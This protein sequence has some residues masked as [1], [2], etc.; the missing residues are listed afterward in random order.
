MGLPAVLAGLMVAFG[1]ATDHFLSA[2]TLRTIANQVPDAMLVATGMTFVV[3]AGGIDLSV[4]SVLALS[5]AVLG[6]VTVGMGGSV[7]LGVSAALLSGAVCG[8]ANGWVVV[9]WAVPSFVVTLGML[10]VARG[11]TYLLTSSQTMYLGARLDAL[12]RGLLLGLG[13]PFFL[14]VAVAAAGEFI[15]RRTVYGRHLMAVGANESAAR[16]S[17]IDPRR[18]RLVA[19]VT[20]GVLTATAAVVQTARLSAA[21]PNAGVGF[22]LA[23]IAAVVIGGTSLV[24][25][26]G[27]V[28][29]SMLG[30]MVMAVLG[31]GL[32]QM[33][34]QEPT[35]RLVTGGVIVAAAV[36]DGYRRRKEFRG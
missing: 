25:G 7:P 17:G 5:G 27:S 15:L 4:G 13:A 34:V 16:L 33:G 23:A 28:V 31:A 26:R 6:L 19:F 8:M 20:C 2:T 12:S 32:A 10:E 9:R 14:A 35:R 29:Q 36:A 18:V 11:A 24:G 30:V 22:E 3:I 1:L 21:D